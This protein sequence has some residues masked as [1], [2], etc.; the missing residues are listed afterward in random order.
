[1]A[2]ADHT[3][4]LADLPA[5]LEAKRLARSCVHC[6]LCLSA[7]PTYRVLGSELD[8]PRGRI[9]QMKL[10]L[11]G[12]IEP[13]HPRFNEHIFQCLACRACETACP[14]GVR[15]GQL[16][17]LARGWIPARTSKEKLLR[18]VVF[19]RILPSPAALK[20][21]GVV[22]RLYQASGAQW[23]V[24][25]TGLLDR[26]APTVAKMESLLPEPRTGVLLESIPEE[27]PAR[28]PATRRVGLVT[29]CIASEMFAPTNAA[30]VRVLAENGCEVVAPSEQRCCGA[31]AVH[32]GERVIARNLARRNIE[33]FER[34]GVDTIVVN[35]AGC[36]STLKEYDELLVRDPRFAGPAHAF[37]DK[38]RD[39][40]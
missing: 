21:L 36:G 28:G 35:A 33:A 20:A 37:T 17:E 22:T 15:Y 10:A 12:E 40:S 38:M 39:V 11:S 7:C 24:R 9:F 26:V 34:A 16:V 8:S 23:L 31:L 27:T 5:A 14:S 19:G 18:R 2:V 32:S 13:D 1:M 4:K 6:G 30:T 29:G 25:A 3:P